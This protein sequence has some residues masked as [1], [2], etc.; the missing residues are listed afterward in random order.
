ML[1]KHFRLL[2][3]TLISLGLSQFSNYK[4]GTLTIELK[5]KPIEFFCADLD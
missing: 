5:I 2:C 4:V 3:L 1:C